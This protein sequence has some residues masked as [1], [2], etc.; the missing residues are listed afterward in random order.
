MFIV[1]A[2]KS[3]DALLD[4]CRALLRVPAEVR[5]KCLFAGFNM[6]KPIVK[7]PEAYFLVP[8]NRVKVYAASVNGEDVVSLDRGHL[9]RQESEGTELNDFLAESLNRFQEICAQDISLARANPRV[10]VAL[11]AS[12]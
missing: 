4:V 8:A 9:I 3:E 12:N 7:Q 10:N 1:F 2:D 6:Q 11:N 5:A